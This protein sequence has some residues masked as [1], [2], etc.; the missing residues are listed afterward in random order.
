MGSR[1]HPSVLSL[2]LSVAAS[3][4]VVEL[5]IMLFL[6]LLD[7]DASPSLFAL[8]DGFLLAV[9][10]SPVLYLLVYRPM[11]G[12]ISRRREAEAELSRSERYLRSV[13]DQFDAHSF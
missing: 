8:L 13:I 10:L 7:L 11:A 4:F 6:P 3:V 2:L 12:E 5:G 1:K 9:L